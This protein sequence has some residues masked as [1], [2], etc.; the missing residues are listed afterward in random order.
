ML[1]RTVELSVTRCSEFF[2]PVDCTASRILHFGLD[3]EVN[4]LSFLFL[5]KILTQYDSLTLMWISFITS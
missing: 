2:N 5:A 1:S 3:D 4:L